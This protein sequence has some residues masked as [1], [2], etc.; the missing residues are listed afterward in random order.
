MIDSAF[1]L[2]SVENKKTGLKRTKLD[3]LFYGD[4]GPDSGDEKKHRLMDWEVTDSETY[5]D[6]FFFT[7]ENGDLSLMDSPF[8]EKG[9]TLFFQYGYPGNMSQTYKGVVHS[10]AG[11]RVLS[12]QGGFSSEVAIANNMAMEKFTNRKLS[13]VAKILFE[14]EGLK[15][16]V[17]DTSIVIPTII[18]RDETVLQFLKRKS[19][20]SGGAYEVYVENDTG[21][22][23]KKKLDSQ[24][25]YT[26]RWGT[27][28]TE[29][30]YV[31]IG[32]PK[33][34]DDQQNTA[35]EETV[36]G[37]DLMEKKPIKEKANNDT[38]KQTS[39]G[40]GTYY[41][42][43][44]AGTRK[45]RP[46]SASAEEETGRAVPTQKQKPQ[47]AGAQAGSS[48][49]KKNA[50]AFK[51]TWVIEGDPLLR[52]KRIVFV[53][54]PAKTIA[55]RWYIEE[56]VHRSDMGGYKTTIKM[57]RNALGFAVGTV[58][59]TPQGGKNKKKPDDKAKN[60]VT[61]VFDKNK[62][63]RVPKTGAS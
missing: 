7:L 60:S 6:S 44:T 16:E 40:K 61:Y 27:E 9:T 17:D 28:T 47:E 24:P 59:A 62:G 2:A 11:W 26:L 10:K 58:D 25:F 4:G 5:M 1:F 54:V 63:T 49:D 50:K 41:F 19:K 30:D 45:F 20:E 34:D 48:F 57:I 18:K 38:S 51:L 8:F 13:E 46:K 42:D 15:A 43:E 35:I 31:T 23:V 39:L 21:Y 3:T 53:D 14:R 29:A 12:I 56:V 36:K 37:F 52:A 32:E 33:Y 22:F 55:G